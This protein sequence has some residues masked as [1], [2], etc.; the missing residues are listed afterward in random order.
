MLSAT[1]LSIH[2]LHSLIQLSADIRLAILES[3]FDPFAEQF[4]S[5]EAPRDD[6]EL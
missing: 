3:R 6:Q 5:A 1:L 2:N 4:R